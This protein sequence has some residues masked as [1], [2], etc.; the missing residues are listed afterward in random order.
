[1]KTEKSKLEAQQEQLDI[2]VVST[3][4]VIEQK[5]PLVSFHYDSDWFIRFGFG[6]DRKDSS[7]LEYKYLIFIDFLFWGFHMNFWRK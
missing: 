5:V 3:S 2:P 6:F 7:V 4:T 1:M